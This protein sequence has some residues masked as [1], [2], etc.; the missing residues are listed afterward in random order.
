MVL[1]RLEAETQ[2]P[3]PGEAFAEA[4]R[5]VQIRG[6]V[7]MRIPHRWT[8]VEAPGVADATKT[9]RR[10]GDMRL[11]YRF[12]RGSQRQI[13]KAHN[14]RRDARF[15]ILPARALGRDAIDELG[16][17]NRPHR[18]RAVRA[19][20]RKAF[21][22]HRREHAMPRRR[23]TDYLIEH[24]A[25]ARMV[26]QV[27]MRIDYRQFRLERSLTDL[28]QP[29]VAFL[30]VARHRIFFSPF[31]WSKTGLQLSQLTPGV[32]ARQSSRRWFDREN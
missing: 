3:Q 31:V 16:L 8:R 1:P 10:C 23:V 20:H 21:H 27:M 6:R 15:A 14:S 9:R 12:D 7:G 28:R 29:R 11:Q 18:L 24:V 30:F 13:R 22:E 2:A 17:A 32:I 25:A 5:F 4:R 26:P 19:I